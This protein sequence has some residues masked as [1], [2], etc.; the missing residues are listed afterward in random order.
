MEELKQQELEKNIGRIL[1][2]VLKSGRR[3]TANI[4]SVSNTSVFFIDKF[5]ERVIVDFSSIAEIQEAGG[6]GN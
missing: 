2:I 6:D 1:K 5:K 4:Q 3:Y